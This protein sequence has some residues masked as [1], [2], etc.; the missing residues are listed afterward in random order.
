[1]RDAACETRRAF[2][3]LW[4][5]DEAR[6]PDQSHHLAQFSHHNHRRVRL[7]RT[8]AE[9]KSDMLTLRLLCIAARVVRVRRIT[10]TGDFLIDRL[11][12]ATTEAY[13]NGPMRRY[14]PLQAD[15]VAEP[16]VGSPKVFLFD[17]LPF[18]I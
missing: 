16:A 12:Q 18:F 3:K 11:I 6:S 5:T 10:S 14:V 4:G 1:M 8:G 2:H 7:S 15:L 13:V 17:V 9:V